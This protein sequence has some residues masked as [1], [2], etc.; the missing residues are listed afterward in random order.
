MEALILGETYLQIEGMPYNVQEDPY[1]CHE[2][3]RRIL[4]RADSNL[5]TMWYNWL[6]IDG[7]YDTVEQCV[8]SY[9]RFF[10]RIILTQCAFRL[11]SFAMS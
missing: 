11:L 3:K 4:W 10:T 5:E 1:H 8:Q 2:C 9:Y 6:V 7:T